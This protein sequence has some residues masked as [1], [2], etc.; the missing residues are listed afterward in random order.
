MLIAA[1][2]YCGGGASS[3]GR[4]CLRSACTSSIRPCFQRRRRR[5][6]VAAANALS[7]APAAL[8]PAAE[9][10]AEAEPPLGLGGGA[11]APAVPQSPQ[12]LGGCS[13]TPAEPPLALEGGGSTPT[14]PH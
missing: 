3:S 7:I 11:A 6:R 8:V 4:W 13:A 12:A 10:A 5:R 2:V 14:V 1:A 9:D